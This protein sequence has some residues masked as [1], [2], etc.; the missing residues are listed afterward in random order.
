M[1][2]AVGKEMK[3]LFKFPEDETL[4]EKE[5]RKKKLNKLK[6]ALKAKKD[7]AVVEAQKAYKLLCCFVVREAQMQWDRIVNEMYMKN[8]WIG[9]NGKSNKGICVNPG[10]RLWT[11]SSS[12]SSPSS[13]MMQ[14]KS[15]ITTCSRQSRSPSES[16]YV[17]LCHTWGS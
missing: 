10:F 3:P 13:L 4:A 7:I 15:S 6:E 8:P 2:V 16:R 1:L 17:N 12:T 9:M 14:L 11:A 5:A